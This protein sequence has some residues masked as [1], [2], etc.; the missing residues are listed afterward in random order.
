MPAESLSTNNDIIVVAN[1]TTLPIWEGEISSSDE[2]DLFEIGEVLF[3]KSDQ[4]N[5]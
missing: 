3:R 1:G 4:V 2:M 5:E